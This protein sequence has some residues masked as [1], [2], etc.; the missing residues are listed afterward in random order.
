[1]N[2]LDIL[3]LVILGYTTARSLARG[4]TREIVGFAASLLALVLG[5]WFYGYAGSFVAPYVASPRVANLL[6][7][8]IVVALVL[9]AGST[10]SWII[11]KFLRT[12][13]LS[14]VDR[15]LGGAFGLL[16]GILISTA[17]LTAFMA[18]GPHAD[19]DAAPDAMVHSRIAP[20]VLEASHFFVAIAPMD[21]KQNFQKYYSKLKTALQEAAPAG[22]GVN[23]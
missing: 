7:F 10:V 4:F 20:Y 16:K 22:R 13:G 21:L 11:E 8:F 3:L 14:I 19:K 1:M 15:L 18:F 2:W 6:G 23:F 9:M 12:I 5:M 17:L